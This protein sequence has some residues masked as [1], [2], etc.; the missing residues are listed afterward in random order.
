MIDRKRSHQDTATADRRCLDTTVKQWGTYILNTLDRG[1]VQLWLRPHTRQPTCQSIIPTASVWR[2]THQSTTSYYTQY[3]NG[4]ATL[5]TSL[6][7]P[8]T[9]LDLWPGPNLLPHTAGQKYS[10]VGLLINRQGSLYYAHPVVR[11]EEML[12]VVDRCNR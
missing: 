11:G 6:N 10:L 9:S 3:D 4:L 2:L 12:T 1:C 8:L 7:E 5:A